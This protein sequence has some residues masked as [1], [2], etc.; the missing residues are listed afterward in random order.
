[1]NFYNNTVYYSYLDYSNDSDKNP[2][3][4]VTMARSID[5]GNTWE[6]SKASSNN[7]FADKE[8]FTISPNGTIYLFYDDINLVTNLGAVVLARSTNGGSSFTDVSIVNGGINDL[9]LAPYSALSLNQ[10][11][12]VAWL[13]INSS[14]N[15]F[16]DIYYSFSTNNGKSF[17][18][19]KDLN[20]ESE[21]GAFT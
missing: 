17:V 7:F 12:F 6:V 11:L 15:N 4:Q 20:P 10:T 14:N 3:S 9:I 5:T 2:Y 19:E 18:S 21:F 8:S 1:M 16:G 13:K